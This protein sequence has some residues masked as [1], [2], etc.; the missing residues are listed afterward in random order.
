MRGS[1]LRAGTAVPLVGVAGLIVLVAGTFLPWL[2]SGRDSRNSYQAGGAAR[3]LLATDGVVDRL[4]AL[5]P[6]VG[7][8]CA[9]AV[10]CYL[11]GLRPIATALAGLSAAAAGVVSVGALATTATS[12]AR[13]VLVGPLITLTGATLVGLAVLLRV[14]T[15]KP[16]SRSPR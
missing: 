8:A 11:F 5:W 2:R 13:V 1:R 16:V 10:A 14:L 9:A 7:L 6:L 3:R 15:V 12:F 4:L